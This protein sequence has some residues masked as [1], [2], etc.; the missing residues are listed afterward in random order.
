MNNNE[1]NKIL[2]QA[3]EAEKLLR[4]HKEKEKEAKLF[5]SIVSVTSEEIKSI[6][7]MILL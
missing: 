3:K 6:Y 5:T 7:I 2:Q 4:E 1:Y